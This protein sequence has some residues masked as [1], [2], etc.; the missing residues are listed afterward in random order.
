MTTLWRRRALRVVVPAA[1]L[2]L[3]A[4]AGTIIALT[5][6]SAPPLTTE[7]CRRDPVLARPA[8]SSHAAAEGNAQ[9]APLRLGLAPDGAVRSVRVAD[10]ILP[11]QR[12]GG[13]FSVRMAG[14]G[15]NLLPNPSF[16]QDVDG[17]GFPD[18]WGYV[19]A[20]DGTAPRLDATVAHSG[21]KSLRVFNPTRRTSAFFWMEVPVDPKTSYVFSAWF[22]S[23][24]VRPN[25][26]T[27]IRETY[28]PHSPLKVDV[29]QLANGNSVSTSSAWGYTG[30]AGWNRQFTGLRTRDD[31][32]RVRIVGWIERGSGT[33]WFDDLYLGRLFPDDPVPVHGT[34]STD[35]QGRT[36]QRASLP[37]QGLDLTASFTSAPDHV[38][39]D[40]AVT[41]D[42]A[43]D[44]AFQVTFTL[45]V[46]ATGWTWWDYAR[47]SRLIGTGAYSYLSTSSL[48]QASRY[49]WGVISDTQ[50][51]L[52][53]GVPLD[54]PR[55]F[56]IAYEAPAGLSITFDLGVSPDAIALRDRATFSFVIYTADPVWGFRSATQ[57]YYDLFPDLFLRRTDPACEGAWFVAPPLDSIARTYLDFGLGLDMLALGKS[58]SQSHATWGLRYLPWDNSRH[59]ATTAY[60]HQ[61]AYY[62]P[63][64]SGPELSY[65]QAIAH[66][67]AEAD[68]SPNTDR[69][70][71]Q[72]DEAT[73]ALA[74]TA[75]DYNGRLYYERFGDFYAYYE[76]LDATGSP[77]D[78]ARTVQVQQVDRATNL[79]T[80]SI[81]W[82]DGIHLDSTS[83][84]R[85]WGAADDYDRQHWGSARLPLTF[86]YDSGQVV[87]RGIFP[88]YDRIA[89]MAIFVWYRRMMLTANF[90]AAETQTLGFVGADHI[91]YFG[92]EQGLA[93][94]A[95]PGAS[96][97]PFAM[98]KRT[99][100]YQRPVS[101]LDHL[102]GQGKLDATQIDRRLQQNLFYGMFSGAF[103]AE[104]EADATGGSATWST[105]ANA[106]LWSR[107]T[108][109]IKEVSRAGWQPV[110]YAWSSNPRVW[111]ERFGSLV[112][113]NLHFALRNETNVSQAFTLT[114]DIRTLGA[115]AAKTLRAVEELTGASLRIQANPSGGVAV[116]TTSLPPRST[117]LL[118]VSE[119]A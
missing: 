99:L 117:R 66:L 114:I 16:E 2:A 41:G 101:T 8:P 110:T 91:D 69:A 83:G 116:L 115:N 29:Q 48:Q 104:H 19:Q 102:I 64:A 85:R 57:R 17:N 44:Q 56:R 92:L 40:G 53:L 31:V 109:L 111:I 93:D 68:R 73:A 72:R 25:F 86:S 5:S 94:R 32:T 52:A 39:V 78:W 108:P 97:D 95:R 96:A 71:R 38:R 10:R 51:A 103:D 88:M 28:H 18:D 23:R 37:A 33:G 100:A 89:D 20:A 11:A 106:K 15:P 113:G 61:W 50:S 58:S 81:G 75:R 67:Q 27:A 70:R 55:M 54:Q 4:V 26:P 62:D 63:L 87:V 7:V 3:A 49:P 42:G 74:S 24:S 84:M 112:G 46:D 65:E 36:Q 22:R 9:P 77:T 105:Q 80:K 107:Y 35:A 21:A 82:L 43:G 79:A 13:G 76:N 45:P 90:N 6:G 14:N 59:I 119:S 98:I 60:T 12:R 118:A 30:T 34:V 47:R 1:G